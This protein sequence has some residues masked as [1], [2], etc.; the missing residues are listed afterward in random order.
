MEIDNV[1]I[2]NEIMNY[3]G[4]SKKTEFSLFLNIRPNVLSNWFSRNTLDKDIILRKI[5]ELNKI[6]L[7][8]G[9]GE[10]LD[11]AD[12]DHK[13]PKEYAQPNENLS[14]VMERLHLYEEKIDFYKE[15]IEKLEEENQQ[16][17]KDKKSV[18]P[19]ERLSTSK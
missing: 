10:M 2:L 9:E 6:W 4:F 12:I 8:T 15:R 11:G 18:V 5:P 3:K 1:K 19:G 13:M 14:L 17:K 7:L 16:L